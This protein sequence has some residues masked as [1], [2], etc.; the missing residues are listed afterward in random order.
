LDFIAAEHDIKTRQAFRVLKRLLDDGLRFH[1]KKLLKKLGNY[2]LIYKDRTVNIS[3]FSEIEKSL[4]IDLIF[5]YLRLQRVTNNLLLIRKLNLAH[6]NGKYYYLDDAIRSGNDIQIKGEN[7]NWRRMTL[8]YPI[9]VSISNP[10][11]NRM[12]YIRKY[13]KTN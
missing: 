1:H 6:Y 3:S 8:L 5:K 9:D 4:F 13:H 2:C 12:K 11:T 7:G 10:Y